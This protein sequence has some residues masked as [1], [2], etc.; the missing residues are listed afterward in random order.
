M[1]NIQPES[2]SNDQNKVIGYNL[3]CAGNDCKNV[4]MHNL[5]L[6]L[7]KKSG[8]FCEDCTRYLQEEGLVESIIYENMMI[9]GDINFGK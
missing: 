9:G 2:N 4:P 6:V 8:W 3:S 5:R 7:I 1:T